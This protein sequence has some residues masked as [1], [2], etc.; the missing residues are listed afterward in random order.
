MFFEEYLGVFNV[1][2]NIELQWMTF[3]TPKNAERI[4]V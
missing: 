3:L 1:S 2:P 4:S